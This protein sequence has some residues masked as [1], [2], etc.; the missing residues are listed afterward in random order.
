MGIM[1]I[2]LGAVMILQ[3]QGLKIYQGVAASDWA[4]FDAATAVGIIEEDL[5]GCFRVTGRYADRITLSRPLLAYDSVNN[6][7]V[8]RQP[9]GYG[10]EVRYYLADAT[11]KLGTSGECLW[12]S[13]RRAGTT[14]FVLD[15]QPLAQS[16]S[17]LDLS[18]QMKPSPR[19]GSV[20]TVG[21]GVTA[22]VKEGGSTRVKRHA[23]EIVLRN[24]DFG[25][26]TSETGIDD[27]EVEE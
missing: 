18:Y 15:R 11:G 12:R 5:Q 22:T 1:A 3:I 4:N 20:A 10:N 17:A 21:L 24:S 6:I 9:L 16:I 26:V 25:P 8:P 13:V 2:V 7:Y 27:P 14:T 19:S 23:S